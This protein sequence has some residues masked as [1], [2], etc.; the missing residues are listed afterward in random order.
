MSNN[1]TNIQLN[2]IVINELKFYTNYS[3]TNI[4]KYPQT[5]VTFDLITLIL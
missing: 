5:V 3:V 1:V 2:D 4:V